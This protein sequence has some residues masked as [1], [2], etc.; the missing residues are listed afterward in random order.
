MLYLSN[1]RQLVGHVNDYYGDFIGFALFSN[2]IFN[3]FVKIVILL[4]Y[5]D[6]YS[7]GNF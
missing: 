3:L 1:P 2:K 5:V 6:S 7:I 4:A